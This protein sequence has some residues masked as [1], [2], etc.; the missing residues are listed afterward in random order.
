MG[1][2][3]EAS[4]ASLP[5]PF[6]EPPATPHQPSLGNAPCVSTMGKMTYLWDLIPSPRWSVQRNPAL[7]K[8]LVSST[9]VAER[10]RTPRL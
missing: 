8:D 5:D 10:P 7:P 2:A 4:W 1:N 3:T 6:S 9:W